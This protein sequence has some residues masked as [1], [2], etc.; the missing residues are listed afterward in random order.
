MAFD[1]AATFYDRF[2][3]GWSTPL[4]GPFAD[5][6]AVPAGNARAGRR[7]RAGQ[8]DDGARPATGHGARRRRGPVRAVRRGGTN[9][10]SGRRR[11]P[12][13]RRV[14]PLARRVLRRRA[15]AARRPLH[16]RS[17]CRPPGDGPG[18]A[19]RRHG[20]GVRLGLR[21][22][23]GAAQPVLAGRPASSIQRPDDESDLAGARGW[24][25][26]PP[27]RGGRP[28]RRRRDGAPGDA[29]HSTGSTTGGSRT[30]AV[31]G[32]PA[33]TWS[34]STSRDG[35]RCASAADRCCRTAPFT[36]TAVAWA[37]RGRA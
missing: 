20:R 32:R 30:P 10:T 24:R 37:A 26:D 17:R 19:S 21:I 27:V 3:G 2:M 12:G 33:P 13:V 4:S 28:A 1:V 8:P 11:P 16:D 14:A 7:V 9:T 31:S 25:S 36:M 18:D 15:R 35:Q 34:G 6:A 23:S 5:L 29:G 22:R